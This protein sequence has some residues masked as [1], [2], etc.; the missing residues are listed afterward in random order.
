MRNVIPAAFAT[1]LYLLSA[2]GV[3]AGA[4]LKGV[5]VK[6]G[7]NPGGT[8]AARTTTGSDGGFVF[9]NLA[10]GSYKIQITPESRT[11]RTNLNSSRSNIRRVGVVVTNEVQVVT[12]AAVLGAGMASTDVEIATAHGKI[13]GTVSG[14]DAAGTG[15]S[16]SSVLRAKHDTVKNSIGN[17]R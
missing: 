14:A 8:A 3:L 6:L 13:I 7:K 10:A 5:D 16:G 12:V 15:A 11:A 2:Q 4:P 1:A 9:N 17:I